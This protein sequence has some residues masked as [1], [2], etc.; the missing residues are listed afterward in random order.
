[1]MEPRI[2]ASITLILCFALFGRDAAA[3]PPGLP[4]DFI[5]VAHRGVVTETIPENSLA[6]LEETIKRGYTH[7][8]VDLLCTQ[9]GHA[10]C[11]HNPNLKWATGVSR[12]IRT[13][14]LAELRESVAEDLVPSFAT[15]CER[16]EGRIDL[17]ID[18]KFC[19]AELQKAFV[20]S[21]RSSLE[22]RSLMKNALFIGRPE[23]GAH[24]RGEAKLSWGAMFAR[25]DNS[26][27]EDVGATY[28]AFGH[29]DDFDK[30]KV[31]SLHKKG[32]DVIVSIN[33]FHYR[34]GD[35]IELGKKD[36]AAML[37]LGVDGLQID[38]VYDDC[39]LGK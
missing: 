8:E 22:K 13:V 25:G 36:V 34:N 26:D 29:A 4:D 9:D 33:T 17:M 31:E 37:A 12:A 35:P 15:F 23:I 30:A 20:E 19:P 27:K 24:F 10:V 7:F 11:T 32:L 2:L 18:A 6:S 28:F 5:L 21:I 16:A 14:T 1:M 3:L 39:I 38:S